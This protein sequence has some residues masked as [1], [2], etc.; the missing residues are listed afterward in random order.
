MVRNCRELLVP[1]ADFRFHSIQRHMV[2]SSTQPNFD[3]QWTKQS[4]NATS[5]HMTE[6]TCFPKVLLEDC[7]SAWQL[8]EWF[9]KLSRLSVK[10][11]L[12]HFVLVFLNSQCQSFS[13][14]QHLL[15]VT[16]TCVIMDKNTCPERCLEGVMERFRWSIIL[17]ISLVNIHHIS[18]NM[19][20]G[21]VA[22]IW[23]AF[24]ELSAGRLGRSRQLLE[25]RGKEGGWATSTCFSVFN[26]VSRWQTPWLHRLSKPIRVGRSRS[27]KWYKVWPL[28]SCPVACSDD[29]VLGWSATQASSPARDSPTYS[30]QNSIL[31]KLNNCV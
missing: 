25:G 9:L 21:G 15:D 7:Q 10:N 6:H 3:A 27:E 28:S 18:K 24:I 19:G 23:V 13:C 8:W 11:L 20:Y 1:L 26:Q 29:Q 16:L 30:K 14:Q 22:F 4:K 31:P 12:V 2:T 17:I 5:Y